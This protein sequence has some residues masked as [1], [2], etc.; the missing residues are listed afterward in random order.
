MTQTSSELDGLLTFLR[1]SPT[2]HHA[3]AAISRHLEAAGFTA[4]DERRKWRIEPGG[5][6]YARRQGT[7]ALAAFSMGA[8]TAPGTPLTIAVAHLD[9]PGLKLKLA[10]ARRDDSANCLAA[11]VEV[12]GSPIVSTWLDRP[13]TLAGTVCFLDRNETLTTRSFHSAS[14]LAVIPNPAIHLNRDVNKGFE[15]NAQNHLRP[16]F[17][18]GETEPEAIRRLLANELRIDPCQIISSEIFLCPPPGQTVGADRS[19]IVSP[20]LDDLA[21]CDAIVNSLT[22]SNGAAPGKINMAVFVDHEEI[23]SRTTSGADSTWVSSLLQRINLAIGG[24]IEDVPRSCAGSF[25]ISA[26]MAHASHPGFKDK[27]D[28]AYAPVINGGPVIKSHAGMKYAT[29]AESEARFANFCRLAGVPVQRFIPRSDSPTG[30]TVGPLLAAQL[31]IPA[32]DVGS[33][34]WGM[35]SA[36]ETAGA[37]DHKWM[38]KALTAGFDAD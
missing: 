35:H 33:P 11:N 24:D 23:G 34:L 4:L 32:V 18:T 19:M 13:L 8:K 25:L 29:T 12:Y 14:P 3:A 9:S 22:G 17:A 5:S 1:E 27:H 16:I 37:E 21:M 30:S 38:I 10:A 20:R 2:A 6:Y 15:Y 7:A 31:G 28:A 26:D 36:V